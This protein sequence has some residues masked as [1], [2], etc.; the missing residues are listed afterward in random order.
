MASQNTAEIDVDK[1]VPVVVSAAELASLNCAI[2]LSKRNKKSRS[3]HI[4]GAEEMWKCS[5]CLAGAVVTVVDKWMDKIQ[6]ASI[7][8]CTSLPMCFFVHGN[9][10]LDLCNIK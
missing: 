10:Y 3:K 6:R 5:Y 4:E 7:H 9:I 2:A 8:D 1:K